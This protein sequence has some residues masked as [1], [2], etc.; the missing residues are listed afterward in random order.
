MYKADKNT[1]RV[2]VNM[3]YYLY[4]IFIYLFIYLTYFKE[5]DFFTRKQSIFTSC[6]VQRRRK[7]RNKNNNCETQLTIK[8]IIYKDLKLFCNHNLHN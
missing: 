8:K 3:L 1:E 2:T 6:C 7:Q 5:N 4:V